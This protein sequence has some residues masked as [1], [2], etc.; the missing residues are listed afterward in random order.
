MVV[1][2]VVVVV[3]V[4]V[5]EGGGPTCS[6]PLP[7]PTWTVRASMRAEPVYCRNQ[8]F[9]ERAHGGS[10]VD[11]HGPCTARFWCVDAQVRVAAYLA[12]LV[13]C[14]DAQVR[15]AAGRD[16]VMLHAKLMR[17][18]ATYARALYKPPVAVR[19]VSCGPSHVRY[20]PTG[21]TCGQLD[22]IKAIDH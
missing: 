2:V 4:C 9:A 6:F 17:G 13:R 22:E 21:R 8:P 1:V 3:C 11:R 19:P 15:V 5:C 7:R 16:D 12:L 20:H 14:V 18:T 10:Q